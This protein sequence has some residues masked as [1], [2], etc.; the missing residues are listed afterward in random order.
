[1]AP[2]QIQVAETDSE[3]GKRVFIVSTQTFTYQL[4]VLRDYLLK[5]RIR[6]SRSSVDNGIADVLR[7]IDKDHQ[8]LQEVIG[9]LDAQSKQST[10]YFEGLRSNYH[11]SL[12]ALR[13]KLRGQLKEL[14]LLGLY[15]KFI[16]RVFVFYN[17]DNFLHGL[18]KLAAQCSEE[19]FEADSS[20]DSSTEE[21]A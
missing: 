1:M 11:L 3:D 8:A 13:S 21:E 6:I 12:S 5:E 2:P 20:S 7:Q 16:N 18:Q 17:K 19:F 9:T 10:V 4:R 14:Q 15:I